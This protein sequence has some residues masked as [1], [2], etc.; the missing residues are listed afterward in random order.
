METLKE[1]ELTELVVQKRLSE[2]ELRN[3]FEI[4]T[5]VRWRTADKFA[6][7]DIALYRK[8]IVYAV[9]EVKTSLLKPNM[10]EVAKKQINNALKLTNCRFGIIT[11][12]NAYYIKD[13]AHPVVDFKKMEFDQIVQYLIKPDVISQDDGG[14]ENIKKALGTYF[15]DANIVASICEDIKY[16]DNQG[17]FSFINIEKERAFFLRVIGSLND[18]QSVYRYTTLDTL[19]AM[20]NKGTYRMNGI[21]GMNDKSE[22]DYFDK[23][24][25][26]NTLGSSVQELNDTYLSSC[27]YLKDDLTM[28]RLYGDDG[29]GI[30]LEFEML[31]PEKRLNGFILAPVNYAEE[32][33]KH[34]AL[35][36]LKKLSDAKIRFAELYKWKHF[37]KPHD[38]YVEE[39]IR[40]MFIDNGRFDNGVIN[41]DWVKTWSYSIINPIVDF[42]LNSSSFPIQL[43]RIIMGP[44]TPELNVNISQIDY[45]ISLRGFSIEIVPSE[46]DNYR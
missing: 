34:S 13:T 3:H 41:R 32:R 35:K 45:L 6:E 31:P 5:N 46:I 11:D 39:E 29:R 2:S 42:K 33:G 44:K 19:F 23:E 16:D 4:R 28:W 18:I 15:V 17:F 14:I 26:I 8:D 22:I 36:M 37:F 30:C 27:S 40:L 10:L 25:K 1:Y 7:F 24:C 38:Y 20:L 43:K 9:V 12:N 21:V